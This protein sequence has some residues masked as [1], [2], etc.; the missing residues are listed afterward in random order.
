MRGGLT[1]WMSMG[2]VK[3]RTKRIEEEDDRKSW[4]S[5]GAEEEG[6]SYWEASQEV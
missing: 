3:L 6:P 2:E 1:S 5:D 4:E